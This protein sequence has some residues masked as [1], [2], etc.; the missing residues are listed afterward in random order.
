LLSD[1]AGRKL[2]LLLTL[3]LRLLWLLL[4]ILDHPKDKVENGRLTVHS[5]GQLQQTIDQS[6]RFIEC[7]HFDWPPR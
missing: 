4:A 3:L 6:R 2:L 7:S 1:G 5:S